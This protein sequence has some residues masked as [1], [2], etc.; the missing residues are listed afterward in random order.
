MKTLANCTLKEFLQQTNKIRHKAA[1]FYNVIGIADI[2]KTMPTLTGKETPEEAE[3]KRIEQGKKNISAI[4]DK[5]ID[6][7]IDATIEIIGLM[8]FKT[9]EEAENMDAT[10]FID[11][12]FEIIGSERVMNFFTKMVKSGLIDTAKL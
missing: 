4:I 1:E 8:C 2:R 3:K 10:E 9:P 5:C 7:N 12:V 6:A 11:V